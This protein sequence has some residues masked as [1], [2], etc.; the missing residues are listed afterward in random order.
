MVVIG[1]VGTDTPTNDVNKTPKF[2]GCDYTCT[3]KCYST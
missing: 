2:T 3:V 1:I